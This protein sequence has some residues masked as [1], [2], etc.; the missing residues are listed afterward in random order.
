MRA[1]GRLADKQDVIL[2]FGSF[3]LVG[4]FLENFNISDPIELI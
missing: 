1:A 2:V 4:E 3:L